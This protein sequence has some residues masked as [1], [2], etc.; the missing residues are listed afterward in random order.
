[1]IILVVGALIVINALLLALAWLWF[2]KNE[3]SLCASLYAAGVEAFEAKNFEKAKD[4]FTKT[5]FINQNYED[6]KYRLGLTHIELKNYTNAKDIFK[7]ILKV[8]PLNFNSLLNLAQIYY[9]LKKYDKAEMTYNKVIE[10]NEKSAEGPFGL[11]LINYEQ[12]NYE[13]AITFFKKAAE[14]GSTNE[15]LEFY[16]TKCNDELR[17]LDNEEEGEE[18]IEKYLAIAED[19]KIDLP[20]EYNKSLAT[21]YAKLGHV[22]KAFEYCQK[23][24]KDNTEDVECYKLLALLQYIKKDFVATKNTLATALHLQPKNKELHNLLSYALCQQVDDCPLQKCRE[25]Y[26]D[27]MKKF[28]S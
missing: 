14:L 9:I 11:G 4:N 8:T 18:I 12:K 16:I 26:N 2:F 15:L 13:K 5:V 23:S 28:L 24:L 1:M 10:A 17:D 19:N 7:Q 6:A 27:V 20:I 22:E 3:A 21:A 25:K